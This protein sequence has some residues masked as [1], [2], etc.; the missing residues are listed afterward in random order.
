MNYLVYKLILIQHRIK[1]QT[2]KFKMNHVRF[3]KSIS[4]QVCHLFLAEFIRFNQ[5][6]N[7]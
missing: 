5:S 6:G 2:R 1:K 3:T 7:P 4:A